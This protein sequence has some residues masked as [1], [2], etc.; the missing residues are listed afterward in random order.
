MSAYWE[1]LMFSF[2][3]PQPIDD[4]S[5]LS[6]ATPDITIILFSPPYLRVDFSPFFVL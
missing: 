2:S 4:N 1:A 3:L 6:I 5:K